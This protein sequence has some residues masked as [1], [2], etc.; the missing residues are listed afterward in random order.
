M[1]NSAKTGAR[2]RAT[3]ALAFTA[4][5]LAAPATLADPV[6]EFYRGKT[7]NF[8]VGVSPGGGY[9]TD[10]RLVARHIVKHIPGNPTTVSQNMTGAT[11]L[12][13][14]NHMYRV[15]PRDGTVIALIQNGL[16]TFQALGRKGAMFDARQFQWIGSIAPTVETMIAMRASGIRTVEDA[17]K[18]EVI[19][20]SNGASGITYMFPLMMNEMLGT[21][22][23]M[24]TGY[25]GSGQLNL[26]MERGEVEARNN[27]WS[28]VR[29]TRQNWIK[30]NEI[31]VLVYSGRKQKDLEG[32]P[33]FE[34]LIKNEEDRLVAR[35]IT[36]GGRLG[37]PFTFAP[38]V[39]ADRVAAVRKAF[40][41]MLKDPEFI[42]DTQKLNLEID[43]ISHEE[44][45]QVID[46]LF[47]V[48]DNLKARAAKFFN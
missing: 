25:Q 36:T 1:T 18:R 8:L 32:V 48:P 17:T 42:S 26:A 6:E 23:R 46:E 41:A 37:R 9:D 5:L 28:S 47:A 38:E 35:V 2:T 40:V 3:C 45:K 15:A 7:L 11:G 43:P 21:R 27:S 14:A 30:N 13:M 16:P 31:H 10:M 34:E 20:G 12:V 22:F 4:A 24:V 29:A 44:M 19:A 33:S 39:P